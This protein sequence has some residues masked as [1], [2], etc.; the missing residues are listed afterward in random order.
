MKT[1]FFFCLLL[2]GECVLA[3]KLTPQQYKE[4]FS[5]FWETMNSQY[6]YFDKKQVDWNKVREIYA[7]KFDTVSSKNS[8]ISLMEQVIYEVYDHHCSLGANM[9]QS[10][11]MV[12]TGTDIWA[13]Y[14][15]DKPLITELRRDFGAQKAGI[16]TG[17]EVIAINGIPVNS[18]IQPFLG[19]TQNSASK[20][21]ALRLSLAGDHLSPRKLTL[22]KGSMIQEYYPDRVSTM[23]EHINYGEKIEHSVYG[24][25]GYIKINNYLGDDA[26]IA[27]FDGVLNGMMNTKSLII[28]LRETPSGGNTTV[29]RAILGRF[30]SKEQFYQK[31]EYFAE[32]KE[33]GVKRSWVE[34]VSPRGKTYTKPVVVLCDHW[35]G[36]VAEG[37]TIAFDG[38]KRATIIGTTMAGLNG[39][40]YSFTMP[41]TKIGF[42][43]PTERLYHVNG[44]P[45][46]LYK[47]AIQ[48]D[49]QKQKSSG[50]Q[51]VILDAALQYLS[52]SR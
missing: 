39:A 25:T 16:T 4:D 30:I 40:V 12:P 1:L 36:S 37:I 14:A 8:F 51:D 19:H 9:P 13:E 41:N 49:M 20:S 11:R 32:E 31:H 42:N 23:L 43:I 18:A 48:V 46:E 22:K 34:I 35:T 29:A 52:N 38:M 27:L 26:I 47:P 7:P 3:Q 10:R 6:C 5:Y 17:M 44:Q 45:R 21:F 24:Q 2:S 33:T 28:D 15:N 50:T